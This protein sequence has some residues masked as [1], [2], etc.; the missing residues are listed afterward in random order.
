MALGKKKWIGLG[1]MLAV[2][3]LV[4]LAWILF[5]NFTAEDAFITFRFA[6][7]IG[8]GNGFAYNPGDPI[9][10]TTTPL[11][12]L[13]LAIWSALYSP[14]NLNLGARLFDVLASL[15]SLLFLSAILSRLELPRWGRWSAIVFFIVSSKVLLMDTRGM[16]MPLVIALMLAAWYAAEVDQPIVSGVLCGLLLWTRLDLLCWPI[17]LAAAE[18]P[19]RRRNAAGL[20]TACAAVYLPWILFSLVYFGSAIPHTIIAKWYAFG[21]HGLPPFRQAQEILAYLSPLDLS[22]FDVHGTA[23]VPSL[24]AGLLTVALAAVAARRYGAE[25][26]VVAAVLFAVL[27]FL[28]LVL[29]RATFD[30]H[31]FYPLLWIVLILAVL[32]SVALV[33]WIQRKRWSFP[34]QSKY[35]FA[36]LLLAAILLPGIQNAIFVRSVQT[37]RNRESLQ[38]IGEWLQANTPSDAT[39]LV[40]PLGYIGFYSG[41]WM[42]DEVGLVTPAVVNLKKEDFPLD[43]YFSYIQPDYYVLHCDDAL[44][45]APALMQP[46][47]LHS[48]AYARVKTFNPLNF[49]P[50]TD[51]PSGLPRG[52]CYQIW[53]REK[54]SVPSAAGS[55]KIVPPGRNDRVM[56]NRRPPMTG[57]AIYPGGFSPA[58][59]GGHRWKFVPIQCGVEQPKRLPREEPLHGT[60]FLIPSYKERF[61]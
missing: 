22:P 25:K 58:H 59:R 33:E 61:V 44:R 15:T 29:S 30:F 51:D 53:Q 50:V 56:D 48:S 16:E 10:G 57:A 4:R 26:T 14:G 23:W 41:R 52:A 34:A 1:T 2:G 37:Y 9:Y 36:A 24:A 8:N 7:Q 47:T 11:F 42:L 28:R 45:L 46:D 6:Q 54:F 5:T 39:V 49:N 40:E 32:G 3:L 27:E 38:A 60:A 35:Y 17:A 13:L 55:G 18:F 19:R 43:S 20:L 12:T 21:M 31:Y